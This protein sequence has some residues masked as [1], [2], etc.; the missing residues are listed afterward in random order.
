VNTQQEKNKAP[1]LEA[2]DTWF[3]KRD[4]A[5]AEKFWSPQYKSTTSEIAKGPD[6][7]KTGHPRV[8]NGW[9]QR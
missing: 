8:I 4:Y 3:N 7:G 1:V 5:A 2:F 9:P 6:Q